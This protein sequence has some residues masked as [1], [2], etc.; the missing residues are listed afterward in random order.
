MVG[1]LVRDA[2]VWRNSFAIRVGY[3][4]CTAGY[5][6]PRICEQPVSHGVCV[7]FARGWQP[8]GVCTSAVVA[9]SVIAGIED[10]CADA[11]PPGFPLS[12]E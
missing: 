3:R 11:D 8:H 9:I 6:R 1:F 2:S 7:P 12:R 5:W 10:R 4:D